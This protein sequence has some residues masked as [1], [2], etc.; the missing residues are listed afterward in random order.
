MNNL[1]L[2]ATVHRLHENWP[3]TSNMHGQHET[4]NI[5]RNNLYYGPCR[6]SFKANSHVAAEALRIE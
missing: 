6:P 3:V 4:C 5:Q 1:T 2:F